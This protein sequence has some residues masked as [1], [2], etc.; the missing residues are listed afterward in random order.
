MTARHNGGMAY[1]GAIVYCRL[2]GLL[3]LSPRQT[4]PWQVTRNEIAPYRVSPRRKY[5]LPPKTLFQLNTKW[6]RRGGKD[7][8]CP[9]VEKV[10]TLIKYPETKN[11]CVE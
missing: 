1:K 3:L 11:N 10:A 9:L 8:S 7:I 5:F 6:I 2:Y 4:V